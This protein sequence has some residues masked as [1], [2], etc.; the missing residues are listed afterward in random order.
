MHTHTHTILSVAVVNLS[1]AKAEAYSSLN[2][3]YYIKCKCTDRSPAIVSLKRKGKKKK[4]CRT[5]KRGNEREEK[6]RK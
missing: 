4:I 5:S 2:T 1:V 3:L 6:S